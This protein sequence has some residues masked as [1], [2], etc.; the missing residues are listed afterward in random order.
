MLLRDRWVNGL[1]N[2]DR[3]RLHTDLAPRR[4]GAIATVQ[5][6]GVPTG[7]LSKFLWG[8]HRIL[9]SPIVHS[10]F[11]GIRVSPSVYS[12]LSEVD[13]FTEVMD[14]VARAGLP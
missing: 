5:I 7:E 2:H 10:R 9:T 3:V 4:A 1:A 11:E 8:R 12:T 13:R 6:D 14:D